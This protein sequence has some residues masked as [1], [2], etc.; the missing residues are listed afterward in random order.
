MGRGW[1]WK[2][3]IQRQVQ[4]W[5]FNGNAKCQK[6]RHR[7]MIFTQWK[8]FTED[9]ANNEFPTFLSCLEWKEEIF[10]IFTLTFLVSTFTFLSVTFAFG[11]SLEDLRSERQNWWGHPWK[12]MFKLVGVLRCI[13]LCI[14]MFTQALIYLEWNCITQDPNSWCSI[15]QESAWK[16]KTAAINRSPLHFQSAPLAFISM[17]C[18]G[19]YTNTHKHR[20]EKSR[21]CRR[22]PHKHKKHIQYNP[23]YTNTQKTH[24]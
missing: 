18:K 10:H 21:P 15:L 19:K 13:S 22:G 3:A 24:T 9:E 20:Q 11:L 14:E 17:Q 12:W 5:A 2:N 6:V 7:W 4:L 8:G 16:L 1:R 23:K